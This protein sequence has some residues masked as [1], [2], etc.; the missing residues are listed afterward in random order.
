MPTAACTMSAPMDGMP[1]EIIVYLFAA[2]FG[3]M[4]AA[5]FFAYRRSR[6]Y[7]LFLIG[8][9][10]AGAAIIAVV[11]KDWWPLLAGFAVAWLLRIMGLD[12]DPARDKRRGESKPQ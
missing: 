11:T 7:G 1:M 3:F 9:T 2:G 12:P 5:L 10:Y 4:A 6:H 8:L